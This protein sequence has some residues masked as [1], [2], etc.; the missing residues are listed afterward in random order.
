MKKAWISILLTAVM[1]FALTACG[2]S[3]TA[4]TNQT[5]NEAVSA[6]KEGVKE[7][8][9]A[10]ASAASEVVETAESA[11]SEAAETVESAVS[12]VAETAESAVSEVTE[13]AE[14][15]VEEVTE[16]AESV[17]VRVGSLKGPTTMGLVNLMKASENGEAE[18]TYE[19]TMATQAD[20]ILA[21]VVGGNIDIALIPANVAAVLY[22][23]TEGGVAAVDI[24][25]LGVLYCVTGDDSINSVKD[26]AGKT[27]ITTGQG[28]TPEYAINFLLA[29]NGITDCTLE[30]KSEATEVAAALAQDPTQIAV[31]P[32]P[33]A[34]VAQVQNDALHAAF[35]LADEWDA[36]GVESR[37]LTGATIVRKAFLEEHPEAVDLF[38]KEHA[39][40]AEKAVSDVE[41]TAALVAEY[42]I[43]EK[44]PIAQKALPYCNIVCITGDEMK[45]ALSGYLSTLFEQNPAAV[46]GAMPAEDFYY[47]GK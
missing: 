29:Q 41:G 37:F 7:T 46:G 39:A 34:T 32:Q 8:V 30:F 43:I 38:I 24:N 25:T 4:T 9:S 35:S 26:F 21:G 23:R 40:S 17:T 12:E 5:V 44:A 16:T 28:S 18:G 10:A 20:E 19:F 31:L 22:K 27:V 47:T 6:A 15:T 2:G 3:Q 42:G 45:D 33:F 14:S 1:V 13:T 11:V 36:L